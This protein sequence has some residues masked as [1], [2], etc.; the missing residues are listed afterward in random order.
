MKV[1]ESPTF[2]FH[3]EA[4][5]VQTADPE[6]KYSLPRNCGVSGK[7]QYHWPPPPTKGVKVQGESL[8]GNPELMNLNTTLSTKVIFVLIASTWHGAYDIETI[9]SSLTKREA[10]ALSSKVWE[11][12]VTRRLDNIALGFRSSGIWPPN[13]TLMMN[14]LPIY[15]GGGLPTKM[16]EPKEWIKCREPIRTDIL[17]LPAS[18]D[19]EGRGEK[20]CILIAG[21]VQ[22]SN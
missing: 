15:Q 16:E 14:R 8:N 5:V 18:L 9:S 2:I 7:R 22:E 3:L 4:D 21:Y 1:W 20:P 6:C 13:F 11:E 17:Q 12:V 19:R 10:I